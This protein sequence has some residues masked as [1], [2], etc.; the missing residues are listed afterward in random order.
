MKKSKASKTAVGNNKKTEKRIEKLNLM[1]HLEIDTE[2][3]KEN[4]DVIFHPKEGWVNF[5][6]NFEKEIQDKLDKDGTRFK[7]NSI[8]FSSR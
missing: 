6:K 5:L 7:V 1:V 2:M 8:S 3:I 4:G